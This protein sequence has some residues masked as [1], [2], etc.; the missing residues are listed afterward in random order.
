MPITTQMREQ[1]AN[2]YVAMFGRAPDG[3]GFG[4]WVNE[5]GNN[6]KTLTQVAD[7]MYATSPAR[8]YFPSWYT[9]QEIIASF[10]TNVL[11]RTADTDGLNF[12]TGK[13]NA[14]G[15]TPGKVIAEMISVVETYTGTD[16]DGIKS[17]NLFVNRADVAQTYA[18]AN[19]SVAGATSILSSVTDSKATADAA[20]TSIKNGTAPG[21]GGATGQTFT[22]TTSADNL[23]GN[24]GNDSFVAVI[25]TNGLTTNGTTYNPGD[26]LN[27]GTGT[28]TLTVS[29]SGTDTGAV[30]VS[31]VTLSSI[32]K[33][34]VLNYETS[35]NDTTIDMALASGTTTVGL[36]GSSA[37][38]DTVFSNVTSLVG[39]EMVGD[40]DLTVSY[41]TSLLA[42][43]SD[44]VSLAVKGA[45]T[46]AASAGFRTW[47]GATT[48]V[49]ETLN[50]TTSNAA[51]FITLNGDNDHKTVVVS[52]DKDLSIT[53]TLDTTVTSVNASA[54][55]GALTI[56]S[57]ASNINIVGGAG[58]DIVDMAATL[59]S[60]DTL[61]GGAGV[62][63]ITLTNATLTSATGARVSNFEHLSAG[64]A[65]T[66][67]VSN[68]AGVT[69]AIANFAGA[70]SFSNMGAATELQIGQV[71]NN[72]VTATLATNGNADSINVTIG[73]IVGATDATATSMTTLTLDDYETININAT[74]GTTA[75]TSTI[76]TLTSSQ[77]SKLVVTGDRGLTITNATGAALKSIDAS[78]HTA[79][80]GFI[81]GTAAGATNATITGGSGNDTIRGGSGNDV[82]TGGAG[83]DSIIGGNGA[84]SY[85]AGA[86]NDSITSGTGNDTILGGDGNDQIAISTGADN[87]SGEAGDDTIQIGTLGDL[88]S[89]DTLAGGDGTDTLAFTTANTSYNL[90]TDGTQFTNVTGF[91]RLLFSGMDG[92]DTVTLNDAAIFGGAITVLNTGSTGD[93]T[94]NLAGVL[95]S[96]NTIT[97]SDGI[98]GAASTVSLG[99]GKENLTLSD[100]NDAI[101]VTAL[102][103]LSS[104]DTIRGG[105]GTDTITF[106]D[107]TAATLTISAAQLGALTGFEAIVIDRATDGA[108]A[109]Y[110]ITLTDA[111]VG[112]NV[113]TG[114]L[115]SV[116]AAA[117]DTT[118]TN[119]ING[120]ALTSAYGLALTGGAAADTLVGGAGND[121]ITG[122][123]GIDRLTGGAGNDTFVYATA[124]TGIDIIS[125][126]DFGTSTTSVDVLRVALTGNTAG[127]YLQSA[128]NVAGST[129]NHAVV[130]M[131]TTAY[132]DSAAAVDAADALITTNDTATRTYM[133]IW[134]STLGTVHLSIGTEVAGNDTGDDTDVAVASFT[135]LTIAG[136]A[137]NAN[138]A[139]FLFA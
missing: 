92:S 99:N 137:S 117:G 7:A 116:S 3:E 71:A 48:R 51:N 69:R 97:F 75:A 39:A 42:G 104:G 135:G 56:T 38:G 108:A 61:D 20:I 30:T 35:A 31:S 94:L 70:V 15:A 25:G 133:V 89:A 112:A 86:G 122:S 138:A 36:A 77:G 34:V 91:E 41:A 105:T 126:F 17:K 67:N 1:V 50:I 52:G 63:R 111:I 10:Y 125:D 59:T 81:M 29:V 85:S 110:A 132:A 101:T 5:L 16:A 102:A 11:G 44:S 98:A 80:A 106:T 28:D 95:G 83:N 62:D 46:T 123:T 136:V 54:L 9:N 8:A 24:T 45:G 139:D 121:S 60:A 37:T 127:V 33:V 134:Q 4:F 19:G 113:S 12:W 131:N 120:S 14:A 47:G 129:T 119:N 130:I 53:N 72:T 22:L 66:F 90:T 65:G 93:N 32:E 26:N 6:G 88:T 27:G 76:A 114:T 73:N 58:N 43:A 78:A 107:S 49:A 57:G 82:L 74:G 103:Y 68:I 84:D 2:L 100:G 115:F 87:V 79:A 21:V 13:L 55:T 118:G 18:E 124:N 128:G 64:D 96:S 40:A 23:V 109:N